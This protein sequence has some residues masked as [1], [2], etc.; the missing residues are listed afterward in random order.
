MSHVTRLCWRSRRQ[1]D[2]FPRGSWTFC[3]GA[4]KGYVN[5]TATVTPARTALA[6]ARPLAQVAAYQSRRRHRQPDQ[7]KL[8][9]SGEQRVPRQHANRVSERAGLPQ[10]R[11]AAVPGNRVWPRG[12]FER[13]FGMHRVDDLVIAIGPT[14]D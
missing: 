7:A 2:K 13:E 6:C 11:L 10:D 3:K 8:G 4:R 12:G 1:D 9:R 5:G 14:V